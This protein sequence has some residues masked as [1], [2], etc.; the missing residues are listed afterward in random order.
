MTLSAKDVSPFVG[1]NRVLGIKQEV[2][3]LDRLGEEEALLSVFETLVVHIVNSCVT[4]FRFRV[5]IEAV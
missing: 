2:E 1:I 5:I 4:T 3:V